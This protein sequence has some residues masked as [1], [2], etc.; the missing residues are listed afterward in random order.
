MKSSFQELMELVAKDVESKDE[1][2]LL[3]LMEK[4][5]GLRASFKRDR[6]LLEAVIR[7]V[8]LELRARS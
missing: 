7:R 2:S 5:I 1:T 3:A 6:D 8:E 4:L